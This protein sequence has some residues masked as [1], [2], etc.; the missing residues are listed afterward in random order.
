MSAIKIWNLTAVCL[1]G[2]AKT[3][4]SENLEHITAAN[5]KFGR[6]IDQTGTFRYDAAKIILD[7]IIPFLKMNIP[8]VIHKNFH[9]CCLQ[10]HLY[11]M[12]RKM[13]HTMS[14]HYLQIFWQKKQS[15]VLLNKF[16]FIKVDTNMFKTD[17]QKIGDRNFY[18]KYFWIQ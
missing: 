15:T 16:M 11:M 18:R 17:F 1:Y 14:S 6:I 4:K 9:G 13:Y 5:M 7:Y 10:F 8:S 12:M 3:H 2:R